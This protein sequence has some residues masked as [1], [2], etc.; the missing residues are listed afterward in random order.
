MPVN[1]FHFGDAG[2]VIIQD[3][4]GANPV[5][6]TDVTSVNYRVGGDRRQSERYAAGDATV[7][8]VFGPDPALQLEVTI[9]M[10]DALGV[11]VATALG[12]FRRNHSSGKNKEVVVRK[13]GT[14][15]GLPELVVDPDIQGM[16]LTDKSIDW[17]AGAD[18][19]AAE[20]SITW[21]GFATVEP[22]E[23]AQ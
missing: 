8:I 20:G 21:T 19:P 12:G 22:T 17:P 9:N 5:T 15:V 4:G 16:D 1:D 11:A 18:S 7:K 23:V 10:Y 2:V 3:Q 13:Q 14:G 6:L